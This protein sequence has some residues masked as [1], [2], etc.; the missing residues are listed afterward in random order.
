MSYFY[1]AQNWGQVREMQTR[2]TKQKKAKL[3]PPFP[4]AFLIKNKNK[5]PTSEQV[6]STSTICLSC[7]DLGKD[8]GVLSSFVLSFLPLLCP[9]Q[10]C[11]GSLGTGHVCDRWAGSCNLLLSFDCRGITVTVKGLKWSTPIRVCR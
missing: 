6:E 4:K 9:F 1:K 10:S 5:T 3:V 8:S 7:Q 11:Q 2:K